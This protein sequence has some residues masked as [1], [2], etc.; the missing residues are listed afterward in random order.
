MKIEIQFIFSSDINCHKSIFSSL[1]IVIF[2][3]V[4][5]SSTIHTERIFAFPAQ[6]WLHERAK[7]ICFAYSTL[8]ILLAHVSCILLY[9]I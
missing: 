1:N 4:T 6:K 3:N 2:L 7:I 5:C 8:L 9:K